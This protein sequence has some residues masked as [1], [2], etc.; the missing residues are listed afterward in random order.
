M[1][2]S[3]ALYPDDAKQDRV[4][5]GAELGVMFLAKGTRTASIL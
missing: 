4:V 1:V 5:Y 2:W 3:L